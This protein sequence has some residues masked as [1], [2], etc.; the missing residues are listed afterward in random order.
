MSGHTP[1]PWAWAHTSDKDNGYVVGLACDIHG[2]PLTGLVDFD[3]LPDELLCS[4]CAIGEHEAATCN[5]ADAHLMA[6]APELLAALKDLAKSHA[7]GGYV[8]ID[9]ELTKAMNTAIAKAE[10]TASSMPRMK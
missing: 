1:G 4:F 7:D 6:A 10:G 2:E 5:Y 8:Q 9:D 3:D